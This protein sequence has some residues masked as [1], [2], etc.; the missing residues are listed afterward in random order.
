[1]AEV[2]IMSA[3]EVEKRIASFVRDKAAAADRLRG[4]PFQSERLEA[5]WHRAAE[6]E[7]PT[8]NFED[9]GWGDADVEQLATA[10]KADGGVPNGTL[11]SLASNAAIT[12]AG[13]SS[14]ATA[15]A[16]RDVLGGLKALDLRFCTALAA[17]PQSVAGLSSLETLDMS[18]CSG[19]SA[20]P[21]LGSL[22]RLKTLWLLLCRKL[23]ALPESLPPALE[24]LD[25]SCCDGLNALPASLP[26][27][28]RLRVLNVSACSRLSAL[29]DLSALSALELVVVDDAP[30]AEKW[31]AAGLMRAS[32]E[33]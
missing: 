19:L 33:N 23:G 8:L 7:E 25:L 15:L 1:M 5:I 31:K 14:L 10:I 18:G 4:D 27:L 12:A 21:A 24:E 20:L 26:A 29:P 30:L 13:V 32:S 9:M 28:E 6:G 17:L 11:V 22:L 2:K 3:A 16:A